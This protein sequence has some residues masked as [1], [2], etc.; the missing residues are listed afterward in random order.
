LNNLK[1][2]QSKI[3]EIDIT[4]YS[5]KK[6][7]LEVKLS[8]KFKNEMRYETTVSIDLKFEANGKRNNKRI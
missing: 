2:K 1:K 6:I 7:I 8:D 4:C 3:S 5:F